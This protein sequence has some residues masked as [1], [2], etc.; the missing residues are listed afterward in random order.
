MLDIF[1]LHRCLGTLLKYLREYY[2]L[3]TKDR[4]RFHGVAL[5]F[6][7]DPE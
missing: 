4:A 3:T 7:H 5:A 1:K 6:Q 2:K